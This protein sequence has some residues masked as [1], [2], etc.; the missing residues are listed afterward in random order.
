MQQRHEFTLVLKNVDES[1][2]NLED[3][4]YEA[5]CDDALINFRNGAVYLDF[6]REATTL[7][8]AVL[9]AIKDV[10]SSSIGAI[11]A[12][13]A[14]EDL[15]TES[16]VAK[17]LHVKRQAVSLWMK[18]ERRKTHSFPK[19]IMKLGDRSPLWKWCEIVEWLYQN[20]LIEEKKL[21]E[22]ATFLENIN[23]ILA[24]RN[25]ID[26]KSRQSLLKKFKNS[27]H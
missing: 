12:T 22:N 5:G 17:R 1:T 11:V 16:E 19:P 14:P 25:A 27:S 4:L 15:V 21:L 20:R 18:G 24:D 10:E 23:S 2:S 13:V 26:R 3:S 7:E 8:E 9:N 6:N